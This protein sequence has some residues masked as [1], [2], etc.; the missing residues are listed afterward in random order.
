MSLGFALGA[1]ATGASVGS[2]ATTILMSDVF[3]ITAYFFGYSLYPVIIPDTV[4]QF[5]P[6]DE[7]STSN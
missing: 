7:A 5:I 1:L 2:A 6:Q 4:D 3:A